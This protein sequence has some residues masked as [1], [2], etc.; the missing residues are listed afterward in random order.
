MSSPGIAPESAQRLL[1]YGLDGPTLARLRKLRP[2]VEPLIG[3]ALD[4][5]IAGGQNLPH[6]AHRW[7]QPYPR[8]GGHT[9]EATPSPARRCSVHRDAELTH[10]TAKAVALPHQ[11][12]S[13][14]RHGR[15]LYAL[16]QVEVP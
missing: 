7:R 6:F 14:I 8:R 5:V 2:I 11:E 15:H 13:D 4:D 9:P 16:R 10:D 1:N 12:G 3:S